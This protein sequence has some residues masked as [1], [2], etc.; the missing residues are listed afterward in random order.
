M[1]ADPHVGQRPGE[2][3]V[4]A[5]TELGEPVYRYDGSAPRI[6]M[7]GEIP[8][9]CLYAGT[10]CGLITDIPTAAEVIAR[11]MQEYQ[12]IRD[13]EDGGLYPESGNPLDS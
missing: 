1:T 5:R 10:G 6:G 13:S 9:M 7:T 11:L 2:D 4:V 3:D 8:E 12:T